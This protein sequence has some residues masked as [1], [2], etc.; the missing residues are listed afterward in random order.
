MPDF[1]SPKEVAARVRCD[2]ETIRRY[3]RRGLIVGAFEIG[4]RVRIPWPMQLKPDHTGACDGVRRNAT[5]RD[6]GGA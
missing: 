3:W 5:E 2:P 4:G 6:S 1:L